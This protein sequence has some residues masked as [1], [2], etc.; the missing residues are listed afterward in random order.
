M[1][2]QLHLRDPWY[3][4][5][6]VFSRNNCVTLLTSSGAGAKEPPSSSPTPIKSFCACTG[7]YMWTNTAVGKYD[8]IMHLMLYFY[9]VC[10]KDIDLVFLVI[11]SIILKIDQGKL[12]WNRWSDTDQNASNDDSD[13]IPLVE[14]RRQIHPS[15]ATATRC[16]WRALFHLQCKS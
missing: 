6:R 8:Q 16:C 10:S 4:E 11:F 1:R 9:A 2:A 7:E 12:E 5:V 15:S 14:P 3:L 13:N